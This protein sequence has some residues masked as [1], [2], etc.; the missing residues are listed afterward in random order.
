MCMHQFSLCKIPPQGK[1]CMC[2]NSSTEIEMWLMEM[3]T[4]GG[5]RLILAGRLPFSCSPPSSLPLS[6]A[7]VQAAKRQ[8]ARPEGHKVSPKWRRLVIKTRGAW[9]QIPETDFCIGDRATARFKGVP[10]DRRVHSSRGTERDG[11]AW[12]YEKRVGG[13]AKKIGF[14]ATLG[15]TVRPD[16]CSRAILHEQR[17]SNRRSTHTV[18]Y[19]TTVQ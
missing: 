5:L 14:H 3:A 17:A 15:S 2:L 12:S 9:I 19:N 6:T 1:C 13:Q 7:A 18:L 4:G 11:M 8:K 16:M 10:R